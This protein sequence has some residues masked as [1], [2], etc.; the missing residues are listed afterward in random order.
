MR[1]PA[2]GN[3]ASGAD[4]RIVMSVVPF[5]TGRTKVPVK[6]APAC[7][8]IVSPG[9]A[10][11]RAAW[12]SPPAFTVNVDAFAMPA[13][14]A[15]AKHTIVVTSFRTPDSFELEERECP[16]SGQTCGRLYSSARSHEARRTEPFGR[17]YMGR[18]RCGPR[19]MKGVY[20]RVRITCTE[21]DDRLGW[22]M[23][24]P[25]RCNEALS[26]RS[27]FCR[28]DH[29]PGRNSRVRAA[30]SSRRSHVDRGLRF[31]TTAGCRG[32]DRRSHDAAVRPV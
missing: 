11:L 23:D 6:V 21:D 20:C 7:S 32:G 27:R 8:R 18:R 25:S 26:I 12:R 14:R 22:R 15:A 2:A 17:N 16:S 29:D 3:D 24:S 1:T 28:L 10:A 31:T 5:F 13:V 30:R 4:E 9:C 19:S